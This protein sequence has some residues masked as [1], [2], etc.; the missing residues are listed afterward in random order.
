MEEY[1]AT[2]EELKLQAR[3]T[4]DGTMHLWD[5]ASKVTYLK[6]LNNRAGLP[7]GTIG[8]IRTE[9]KGKDGAPPQ[10]K[11]I[12]YASRQTTV[13]LG[14]K[15]KI[16]LTQTKEVI[17]AA[18][19]RYT[20]RA[21]D[22]ETGRHVD[23]VG[24]CSLMGWGK[25]LSDD[26]KANKVMHAE[27]KA[28][29]RATLEVCGLAFLDDTEVD[30]MEGA[31]RVNVETG[32]VIKEDPKAAPGVTTKNEAVVAP[33]PATVPAAE[34]PKEA[35]GTPQ[36]PPVP[37]VVPPSAPALPSNCPARYAAQAA[38]FQGEPGAIVADK[39][40]MDFI[41]SECTVGAGWAK[42]VMSKWL[43]EAFGVR[44]S[45]AKETLTL[46]VF[47]KIMAGIDQALTAGGK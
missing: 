32:E 44:A 36:V 27:T 25:P 3:F 41:V 47:G 40:H 12:P 43:F 24:A 45:N 35:A 38:L 29:R 22:I 6:Y 11:E 19:V 8:M 39:A 4:L 28:K 17:E 34:P 26:Q 30:D 1:K 37:T 21:T 23:A 46:E 42:D 31:V 18:Q 5:V 7:F 20:Y 14:R 2:T 15:H 33:A 13:E 16:S 10:I 9:H